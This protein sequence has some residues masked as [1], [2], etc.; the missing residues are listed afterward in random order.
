MKYAADQNGILKNMSIGAIEKAAFTQ[1]AKDL[2]ICL[3]KAVYQIQN[4]FQ[5]AGRKSEDVLKIFR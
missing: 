5:K 4:D 2:V 3:E 1:N